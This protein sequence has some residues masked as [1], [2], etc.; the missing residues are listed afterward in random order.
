MLS[1]VVLVE[2]LREIAIDDLDAGEGRAFGLDLI[3]DQSGRAQ[4]FPDAQPQISTDDVYIGSAIRG[5]EPGAN[6]AVRVN[7]QHVNFGG[8]SSAEGTN[9]QVKTSA[10]WKGG[11]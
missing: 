2:V 3:G 4:Y 8:F 11:L 5:G 10:F 7:T 6:N 1:F 9:L